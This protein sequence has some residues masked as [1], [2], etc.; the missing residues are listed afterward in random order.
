MLHGTNNSHTCL[1]CG[2]PNAKIVESGVGGGGEYCIVK[3]PDCKS[4]GRI[5]NLEPFRGTELP[6]KELDG[7]FALAGIEVIKKW[8]LPNQYWGP[9]DETQNPHCWWLVKT[10]AG[11]IEIGWR[12]RVIEINWSD[13]NVKAVITKDDVTK[14]ETMVHAHTK[15]KALEYL[16]ELRRQMLITALP[17]CV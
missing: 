4:R 3:C 2:K 12:K 17:S 5:T 14:S 7:L 16:T 13:T 9:S 10:P 8:K 11:L 15:E 6:E 1:I